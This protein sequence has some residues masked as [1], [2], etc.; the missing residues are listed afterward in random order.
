MREEETIRHIGS[1]RSGMTNSAGAEP[2]P[3]EVKQLGSL[4]SS[5]VG[6]PGL[7]KM[8]VYRGEGKAMKLLRGRT[9]RL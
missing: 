2:F 6:D 9:A 3:V 8:E 7:Q 5:A 4:T 1:S